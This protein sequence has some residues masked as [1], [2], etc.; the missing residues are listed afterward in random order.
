MLSLDLHTKSADQPWPSLWVSWSALT[1][2][3]SIYGILRGHVMHI[4]SQRSNNSLQAM[5]IHGNFHPCF[6]WKWVVMEY[7]SCG[8]EYYL[9]SCKVSISLGAK[10]VNLSYIWDQSQGNY[11]GHLD[12]L[13]LIICRA[14]PEE[15]FKTTV[16]PIHQDILWVLLKILIRSV[17][18]N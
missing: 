11:I 18:P 16:K 15:L 10:W 9:C 5:E 14:I 6:Q 8:L 3:L 13:L 2:W 4:Y 1:L 7:K 17:W 12:L